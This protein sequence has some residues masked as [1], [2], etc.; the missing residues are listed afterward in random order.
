[1]VI[2]KPVHIDG[3]DI[4][5]ING[6]VSI[7]G[8]IIQKNPEIFMFDF[9][10]KLHEFMLENGNRNIN[11]NIQNLK[12]LNSSGIKVIVDW[13]IKVKAL[14]ENKRYTICFIC[15]SVSTWQETIISTLSIIDNRI[16]ESI[17]I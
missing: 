6:D 15:D 7:S 3:V 4:Q 11:I 5:F 16:I 9:F 1:M 14:P 8:N 12:F 10:D 13:I 2:I 17:V